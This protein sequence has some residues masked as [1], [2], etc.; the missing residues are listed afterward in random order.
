MKLEMRDV[1]RDEDEVE[2]PLAGDLV[3]DVHIAALAYWTSGTSTPD[4]VCRA[5][6]VRNPQAIESRIF[7]IATPLKSG[8]VGRS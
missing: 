2:R 7:P 6:R 5:H 4:S 8:I 3:G 1:A